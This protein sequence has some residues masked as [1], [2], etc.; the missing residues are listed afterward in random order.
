M[1]VGRIVEPGMAEEIV[2]HGSADMVVLGRSLIADPE[3]ANKAAAGAWDDIAPCIGCGLG[4]VRNRER[5]GDMTCIINPAVGRRARDGGAPGIQKEEGARR[6]RRP[7][8]A[9]RSG[10]G[11]AVGT[12]RDTV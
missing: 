3:W 8:R 11:R 6:G 7:G 10:V 9:C 5:G 12:R 1:V 2:R 4:C